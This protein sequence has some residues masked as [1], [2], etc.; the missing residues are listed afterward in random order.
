M[1]IKVTVHL[2]GHVLLVNGKLAR[3]LFLGDGH[4]PTLCV[5]RRY[6]SDF[7]GDAASPNQHRYWVAQDLEYLLPLLGKAQW[8]GA[9]SATVIDGA[10]ILDLAKLG[11]KKLD[12]NGA[13]DC[14][15]VAM[16]WTV[17]RG[18]V[19]ANTAEPTA[20]A[21][22]PKKGDKTIE[23]ATGMV[24]TWETEDKSPK[25]AF[26]GGRRKGTLTLKPVNGEIR[27]SAY[28]FCGVPRNAPFVDLGTLERLYNLQ[29]LNLT[30]ASSGQ[31]DSSVETCPPSQGPA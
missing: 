6:F 27:L 20:R 28:S 29:P 7:V 3:F 22:G 15:L 14:E 1:A 17:D 11:A 24:W 8:G 30:D 23:Y 13:S 19:V 26:E 12:A 25:I 16:T 21:V 5:P 31:I 9:G 18:R 2:A 4:Q 10:G